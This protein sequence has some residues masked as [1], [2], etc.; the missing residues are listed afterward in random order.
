LLT[1]P[2]RPEAQG[3]WLGSLPS[4][5]LPI[6]R[7]LA[8]MR[9]SMGRTWAHWSLDEIATNSRTRSRVK[10]GQALPGVQ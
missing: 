8:T 7:T 4:R 2:L 6:G 1:S 9:S 3:G 10:A 5:A